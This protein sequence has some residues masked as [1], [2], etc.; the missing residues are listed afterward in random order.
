M[1]ITQNRRQPLGGTTT[2]LVVVNTPAP[3]AF[4]RTAQ[5]PDDCQRIGT[6]HPVNASHANQVRLTLVVERVAGTRV[7]AADLAG[8]H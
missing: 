1:I 6:H 3:A 4:Q 7:S 5:P 8:G 2:A